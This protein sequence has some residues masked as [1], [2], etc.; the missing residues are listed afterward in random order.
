M[1]GGSDVV[2]D[3]CGM[4]PS[5]A[6]ASVARIA[7]RSWPDAVLVDAERGKRFSSYTAAEFGALHEIFV[8]RD[9]ASRQTWEE[10]GAAGDNMN[11]IVYAIARDD[12]LTL[13]LEDARA[14]PMTSILSA[15]DGLFHNG[16]PWQ[17]WKAA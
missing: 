5:A 17:S 15:L 11:T 4:D 1:I 2:F 9:E 7:Q 6:L 12:A 13:V 16:A 14:A 10:L 3:L 8:F